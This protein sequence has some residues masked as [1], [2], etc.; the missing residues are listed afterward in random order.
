MCTDS[1]NI[2]ERAMLGRT[3]EGVCEH[4]V[5]LGTGGLSGSY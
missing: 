3:R 5:K 4:N 1:Y 2:R